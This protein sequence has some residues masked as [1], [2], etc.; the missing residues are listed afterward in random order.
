[1]TGMALIN[2]DGISS[3]EFMQNI[4]RKFH[5]PNHSREFYIHSAL[6]TVHFDGSFECLQ[7]L[8][9]MITA[10]RKQVGP[11]NEDFTSDPTKVNSLILIAS[12]IGAFFCQKTGKPEIWFSQAEIFSDSDQEYSTPLDNLLQSYSVM[13]DQQAFFPLQLLYQHL[14]VSEELVPSVSQK[15]EARILSH[16]LRHVA[17]TEAYNKEMHFLQKMYLKNYPLDKENT[18]QPLINLCNLDYSTDSLD[19]LDELLREIRQ[20]Y[21]LM[22]EAFLKKPE[23]HNFILFVSG[24]LGRIIAQQS[25]ATLRWLPPEQKNNII[26]KTARDYIGHLRVAQINQHLVFI[27]Q[28]VCDF[29]FSPLVQ[30]SSK[31]Y[32]ANMVDK[33]RSESTPIYLVPH[34]SS[35]TANPFYNVLFQAGRL[36]GYLFQQLFN[37]AE[38]RSTTVTPTSFPQGNTF[39][40]HSDGVDHAFRQL[41]SN[42]DQY[43][44]NALGYITQVYLPHLCTQAITL[45][46]R[47]FSTNSM[48]LCLNIP[49]FESDDYRGFCILQPYMFSSDISTETHMQELYNSMG[50][51]YEGLHHFEQSIA[52]SERIW[53]KYYSPGKHPYPGIFPTVQPSEFS[54]KK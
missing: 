13:D 1:M 31:I 23:N 5:N 20:Q 38:Q 36:A 53:K 43:E 54:F 4:R 35:T 16:L 52:E 32:T 17:E 8:D 33:I 29:L 2:T 12:Y 34:L 45:N 25:A 11:L 22:P 37:T 47:D 21:R 9:Q 10:Y 14:S 41:H 40:S 44:Y 46:I 24:Y 48:N 19:R 7:R 28:H 39:I 6:L 3:T 50:A 51:F 18:F 27:A 15:I 49:F 42:S 30:T 26:D